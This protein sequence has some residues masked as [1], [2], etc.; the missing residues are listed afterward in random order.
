MPVGRPKKRE[1]INGSVLAEVKGANAPIHPLPF[2][3][4]LYEVHILRQGILGKPVFVSARLYIRIPSLYSRVH[5]SLLLP[6]TR[7]LSKSS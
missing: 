2:D 6:S 4:K 5:T 1:I 3:N 7:K